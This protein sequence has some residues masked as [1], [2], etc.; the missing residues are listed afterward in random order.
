MKGYFKHLSFVENILKVGIK[1]GNLRDLPPREIAA[2][3]IAFDSGGFYRLDDHAI[4]R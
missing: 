1:D 4:K 2:A 3:F